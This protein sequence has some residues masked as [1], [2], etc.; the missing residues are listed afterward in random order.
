MKRFIILILLSGF[1]LTTCIKEKQ[2]EIINKSGITFLREG[3]KNPPIEARPRALWDWVDGNFSLDEITHEMEEAKEKGMGGFDIW[4]VSKVMDENNIV[5]AG[6]AFMS[7]EY[8]NGIVHAIKEAK[9]LV[10]DL[11]LIVAS[12]WNAGGHWTKPEHQTMG[13]F[14]SEKIIKSKGE[15]IKIKMSFP[16]LPDKTENN[17]R[18]KNTFIPRGKDGLPEYYVNIRT[19]A[20]PKTKDSASL[21]KGEIIDITD[22]MDRFGNLEWKAPAGNWRIIRYVCTNTGQPMISSSPNSGGPMIDHFN[23]EATIDHINFFIDKIEKKL[24]YPI[25]ESGIKYFYTD[26]Y[27]V[28][29]FLWTE[30][31]PEIFEKQKGYSMI[32]FLPVFHGFTVENKEITRRFLYDYREVWS[33]LI[34]NSHYKKATEICENHG[35]GFVAEAAGPGMPIH[36]CPFESIKSSGVLS[37]PRGEFWHI[38]KKNSFFAAMDKETRNRFSN[39]LQ[40]IKGVSSASHLYNQKFVEAEAFTGLHIWIES[41]GDL[42]EDADRAFCEGLNRIV[43]HTWPHTPKEA[44]KPG[45]AYTFGTLIHENRIWWPMAKPW[46]DYLGRTSFMLQQGNFVGDVLQYYGDSVPNFAPPKYY[47][48]NMGYGY[49]YDVTNSDIILNKL[50]VKDHELV[51]DNGQKYKV[52]VLPDESYMIYGVLKKLSELIAGGATVIGRKP[53]RSNGLVNWKEDDKKVLK[54]ANKVWGNCDGKTVTEHQYGKGKIVWGKSVRTVLQEMNV[55]PDFDFK[56]N[57]ENKQLDFIHRTKDK[58][59]IYFIRNK[60]DQKVFGEAQFRVTGKQPEFWNPET[61]KINKIRIFSSNKT[62]T[63][64][65]VTLEPKASVFVVFTSANKINPIDKITRNQDQIFPVKKN[66]SYFELDNNSDVSQVLLYNPGKYVFYYSDGDSLIFDAN[67]NPESLKL[68]GVWK[69]NFPKAEKGVS[70][71]IFDNLYSWHRSKEFNI[72][73]FSGTA[74]YQKEIN[75][76]DSIDIPEY[77]IILD[78][79]LV[80][81]IAHV[82]VNGR[83]AGISWVKPNKIDVSGFIRKGK[84]K[85]EIKVANTW[86]NKLCGDARL[87]LNERITKTNVT[88]LPNPWAY[89]MKDIPVNNKNDHYD[90]QESGL[91]GPVKI[92]FLKKLSL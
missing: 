20:L 31:L 49:D 52:L 83:D 12:G 30:K 77:K 60:S 35:I 62:K 22:E 47:D 67:K 33:D 16:V 3:F 89:P 40:V 76:P 57:V 74:T 59:E 24:G 6:P 58:E 43:F 36:N 90:L 70:D 38:P 53:T 71:V 45:W 9:R 92:I 56:G 21:K 51:L 15:V 29:G 79:G 10:L 87:P 17:N 54:L 23:P 65:P 19:L 48:P 73:F 37:F 5:P 63:L 61:G 18:S 91:L 64:M 46:M 1:F 27:E 66:K 72:R 2:K 69:V 26:S 82:F 8:L 50:E 68:S 34:I 44:G 81:D 28:K 11:G 78:L 14:K 7:D 32:P 25:G 41:P 80:R 86:H 85:L 13:L 88:R 55:E 84:N 75:I 42:K 39:D 4:D